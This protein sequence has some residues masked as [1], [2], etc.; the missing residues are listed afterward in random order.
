MC[1]LQCGPASW[2]G[3]VAVAFGVQAGWRDRGSINQ[4]IRKGEAPSDKCRHSARARVAQIRTP[5]ATWV[6][7]YALELWNMFR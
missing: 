7:E 3:L 6:A 5:K 1:V 4:K 2:D